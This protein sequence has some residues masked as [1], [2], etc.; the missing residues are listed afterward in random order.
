MKRF[1]VSAVLILSL[2]TLVSAQQ[3]PAFAK[4]DGTVGLSVSAVQ[5]LNLGNVSVDLI[6]IGTDNW[7]KAS[8]SGGYY[9]ANAGALLK[10]SEVVVCFHLSNGKYLPYDY[11]GFI[12]WG[13]STVMPNPPKIGGGNLLISV[14]R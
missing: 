6:M 7:H 13:N 9:V 10:G 14:T 5:G 4:S 12:D 8:V 3:S 11:L 2:V 1:I